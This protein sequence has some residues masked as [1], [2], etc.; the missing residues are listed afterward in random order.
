MEFSEYLR[1]V[2]LLSGSTLKNTLNVPV[3]NPSVGDTG[4]RRQLQKILKKNPSWSR[5]YA[6]TMGDRWEGSITKYIK[7]TIT[8]K[9][10]QNSNSRNS[11]VH[12]KDKKQKIHIIKKQ[13]TTKIAM[14]R[15]HTKKSEGQQALQNSII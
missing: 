10:Q 12:H 15:E 7:E 2:P 14:V 6:E 13:K 11:N 4:H 5:E 3:R 9:T 1:R 8:N